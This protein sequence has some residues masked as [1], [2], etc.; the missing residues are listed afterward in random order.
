MSWLAALVG[1][2]RWTQ[3]THMQAS[4]KKPAAR[5]QKARPELK[6]DDAQQ[7]NA[8]VEKARELEADDGESK[9]DLLMERLAKMKPEPRKAA[10][11]KNSGNL[12]R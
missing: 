12:K 11:A 1:Q 6:P 10:K 2:R 5:S 4:S 8:F 7:S 9:A 3:V